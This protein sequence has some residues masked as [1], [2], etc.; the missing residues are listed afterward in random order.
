MM[1][2][3]KQFFCLHVH[4]AKTAGLSGSGEFCVRCLKLINWERWS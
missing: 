4:T 3:L 2:K 1:K